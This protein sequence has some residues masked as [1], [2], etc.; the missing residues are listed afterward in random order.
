MLNEI[1]GL[2]GSTA[3]YASGVGWYSIEGCCRSSSSFKYL[4]TRFEMV[5]V[6][7]VAVL[8]C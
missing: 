5:V 3:V 2:N 6:G 1:E 7:I 8:I 4:L